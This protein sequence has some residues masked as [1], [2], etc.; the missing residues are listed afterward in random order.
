MTMNL[1]D[2]ATYAEVLNRWLAQ[3]PVAYAF[4]AGMLAS[5]NPC[6]FLMLPAYATYYVST[7]EHR[8]AGGAGPARTVRAVQLGL[9]ATAGFL[10]VFGPLGLVLS[11]GGHGLVR[12]F[13]YTSLVMGLVLLGLGISLL[14]SRRRLSLGV[15][16]RVRLTRS[17][18]ARGVFLFGVGYAV[19]S[20]GCT[21]PIFIV[22]VGSALAASGPWSAFVQLINYGLGMGVVLTVVSISAALA[23][24][25]VSGRLQ[26]LLPHVGR[27]G[28]VFLVAAGAYLVYYWVTFGRVLS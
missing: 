26:R 19:A 11:L 8:P 17:R 23:Q 25:A 13:P 4:G 9:L 20:L 24:G 16:E 3:L 22:V 10:A 21:L 6:G 12:V 15:S 28:G 18:S 7:D 2:P 27:A 1:L 5:V 14:V